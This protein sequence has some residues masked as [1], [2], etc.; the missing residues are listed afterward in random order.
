MDYSKLNHMLSNLTLEPEQTEKKTI[1]NENENKKKPINEQPVST[2]FMR[3]LQTKEFFKQSNADIHFQNKINTS[4]EK[5][6]KLD[7]EYNTKVTEYINS[8][9][10]RPM[11][12]YHDMRLINNSINKNMK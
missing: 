8:Q 12:K 6:K 4:E 5:K 7:D 2:F 11:P 9:N 3:E 10:N 1:E